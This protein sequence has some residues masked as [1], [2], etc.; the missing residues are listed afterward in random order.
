MVLGNGGIDGNVGI[1]G[2]GGW[3]C[4]DTQPRQAQKL[5]QRL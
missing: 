3:W 2:I 4:L 5:I 1:A